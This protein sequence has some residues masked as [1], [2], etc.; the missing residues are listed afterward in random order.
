MRNEPS[1]ERTA[2]PENQITVNRTTF[3]KL[4][5]I[6]PKN[7]FRASTM[8]RT[9][10]EAAFLIPKISYLTAPWSKVSNLSALTETLRIQKIRKRSTANKIYE[11]A[12]I[13][14][15]KNSSKHIHND[16][17]SECKCSSICNL[18][19]ENLSRRL[20]ICLSKA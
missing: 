20:S 15:H 11:P 14:R 6:A 19:I 7:M 8:R 10:I 18:T 13:C 2:I 12:L 16:C 1:S 3:I 17:I 9:P 5:D 4:H